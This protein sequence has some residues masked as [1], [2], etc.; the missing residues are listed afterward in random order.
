MKLAPAPLLLLLLAS[1]LA[2]FGGIAVALDLA[3]YSVGQWNEDGRGNHR[4]LV[5]VDQ[6]AQAVKVSIPWR[7]R[8]RDAEGKA[9]LVFDAQ[10]GQRIVN[11]VALSITREVGELAFQPTSGAGQYEVYYLP[12]TAPKGNFDDAG[13]YY[14]PEATAEVAW[15]E[16]TGLASPS[17]AGVATLPEARVLELQARTEF[18]RFDPMEVV[19]TADEVAALLAKH[20]D[21]DYLVFPE[22]RARQVKMPDD[23][24]VSWTQ[25]GPAAG[26]SGEARPGENYWFQLGVWAAR[27]AI[28]DV[29]LERSDLVSQSGNISASAITCLNLEGSDWLGRPIRPTFAVGEGQVRALWVG[30]TVPEDAKGLY[31]GTL[32]LKPQGLPVQTIPVSLTVAGEPIANA[33]TDDLWRMARLSWLDST[34]GLDDEVIAPFTPI[35]VAGATLSFVLRSVTY[36]AVGLPRSIQA[37]D[38]EVLDSP[39]KLAA[40]TS[41]GPIEWKTGETRLLKQA[42]G[43]VE[44]QTVST[45]GGLQL[46]LTTSTEADGCINCWAEFEATEQTSLTDLALEVPVA[47]EVARYMMGLS[48]RGGER[49][50]SW[51]WKWDARRCDNQLWLGDFDAGLQ[52]SLQDN[53]DVWNLMN[54]ASG[55]PESWGNGGQGGATV[56]E[57][58]DAFILRAF[59]GPR[60]L[61]AGEQLL[62]RFRFYVTP[63]KPLDPGH[64]NW[65]YASPESGGNIVHLHHGNSANPYINYPFLTVDALKEVVDYAKGQGVLTNRG[66]VDYP[67]EQCFNP[68]Q[69]SLH[70]WAR[71]NFDP[72]TAYNQNLLHIEYPNGDGIG[73]YWNVDDHGMRAYIRKGDPALNQYPVIFGTRSDDWAEGQRHLLTLSWGHE[74]AIYV[75]GKLMGSLPYEGTLDNSLTGVKVTF[76]GGFDLATL[77]LSDAPYVEGQP[78][79]P[80]ADEHTLLLDAFTSIDLAQVSRAEAG[81]AGEVTGAAGIISDEQGPLL[82]FSATRTPMEGVNLYYTVRELS[83]HVSELWALRSLGRE[84]FDVGQSYVYSVEKTFFGQPGGGYP[85]LQEHLVS[86]YVPAWRQPLPGG[87]TDAAIAQVGLSRWH[88][89]YVEGMRWLMQNTGIDGLYL[90]GIGYDREIMKRIAKVMQ[91]TDPGSRINFH[92][93]NN[94][95]F[96]DTKV[97]PLNQYLEHLP[98]FS[99]LWIGEMYDY[100]SKPDYWLVE[101]SGLPFGLTSEMLNYENGGNQWRGMLYGMTGRQNP[102]AFAMWRFWDEFG[103]QDADWLGYWD[104]ACPVKTDKPG[105]LA[106]VYRKP[107]KSLIALAQWPEEEAGLLAQAPLAASAPK[108]DGTVDEAEW[109]DAARL[110]DF[111]RVGI[112][113]APEQPTEAWAKCAEGV[114]YIGWRCHNGGV[115]PKATIT[116]PAGAVWE[117]DDFEVFLQPDMARPDYLHFVGNALGTLFRARNMNDPWEGACEYQARVTADAWEGELA[118]PLSALGL[119][120]GQPATLGFN[121]ARGHQTPALELSSWARIAG[122]FHD[123]SR[124]ARLEL[125]AQGPF[126]VEAPQS[127]TSTGAELVGLRIDWEALGLD[128]AKTKLVAPAIDHFQPEAV[129]APTEA[130]PVQPAKGWLLIAEEAPD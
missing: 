108:V 47:E 78:I 97:S 61:A 18:N 111:D 54:L 26:F 33:G 127:G 83:N 27:Q 38:R 73:F 25:T 1:L 114:L 102:S 81:P 117:D 98:Y 118:V 64:W 49:P 14:K 6:A 107:G 112:G 123:P 35:E 69:G 7:R 94:Y 41:S 115:A 34:L 72:A 82:R 92:S 43:K 30:I 12:Y 46:T 13:A 21:S 23:L 55:V 85:W 59:T 119:S 40:S 68:K 39:V 79:E 70:V 48:F 20:P 124:F 16:A 84:I 89:Y 105:V 74:V 62:L 129:F 37:N 126:T 51:D 19:A 87:D 100:N 99:N 116:D 60:T 4:A 11:V 5:Q 90:D 53:Q 58:D 56:R 2:I 22:D 77:K 88:N 128:P 125:A 36:D 96:M 66:Q 9:V 52:V 95:D 121:L 17:A 44:R 65:R 31:E 75:D 120:A 113:G 103:I 91:R 71:L 110:T 57:E 86:G 104:P 93:G 15:L 42:P 67:A 29:E 80:V 3:N 122:S 8:D 109:A 10:T 63:L 101:I 32:T 45:G 106:T 130:I 76:H 24:P 28:S 50:A